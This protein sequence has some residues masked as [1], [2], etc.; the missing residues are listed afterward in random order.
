MQLFEGLQSYEIVLMIMGAV[1]FLI[2]AC[3]LI[4]LV[5]NKRSYKIL[6]P[7]FIIPIIMVGFP[8]IQKITFDEGMVEI[9]KQ[10]KVVNNNPTDAE[11]KTKLTAML[12]TMEIRSISQPANLRIMD[13]AYVAIGEPQKAL[14]FRGKLDRNPMV[15][16]AAPP[17]K[18]NK[19]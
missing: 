11:A 19:P 7:S 10:T 3:L 16:R 18:D 1:F 8:G 12:K 9:E 2:L 15:E 14:P 5:L 17:K 13:N 4:Y 6:L